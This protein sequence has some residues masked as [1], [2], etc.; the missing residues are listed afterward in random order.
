MSVLI[1]TYRHICLQLVYC[2]YF[3]SLGTDMDI[4]E[5][6]QKQLQ[7]PLLEVEAVAS[8]DSAAATPSP[9]IPSFDGVEQLQAQCGETHTGQIPHLSCFHQV[10]ENQRLPKLENLYSV[11]NAPKTCKARLTA[12]FPFIAVLAP[13]AYNISQSLQPIRLNIT[14]CEYADTYGL[15]PR[16]PTNITSCILV[17]I[18]QYI[19]I[20]GGGG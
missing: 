1:L 20:C 3:C 19:Y 11:L 10:P 4:H 7:Q 17:C 12:L 15:G 8:S 18:H 6:D 16:T 13:I 14:G 2:L 9:L 5:S